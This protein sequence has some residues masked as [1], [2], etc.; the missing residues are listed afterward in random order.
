MPASYPDF[1]RSALPH[2]SSKLIPAA[3][4]HD[5]ATTEVHVD[6]QSVPPLEDVR[7]R[8]LLQL[9]ESNPRGSVRD[10]ALAFN[11][12]NSHLQRLFKRAT[13]VGLSRAFTEKRLLRAAS[14]LLQTNMSVKEVAHAVGYEHTSSFTRAFERHFEEAPRH[15]RRRNAA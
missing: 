6:L 1:R 7:L 8:K 3:A 2:A 11:L 4:D 9:M 13:G 12:S 15:Y 10:W 5:S 14:L